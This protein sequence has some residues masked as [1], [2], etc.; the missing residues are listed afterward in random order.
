MVENAYET[1]NYAKVIGDPF[2]MRRTASLYNIPLD[3]RTIKTAY[4]KRIK[5]KSK[6]IAPVIKDGIE[7]QN[8]LEKGR[9]I[10]NTLN[11]IKN[12]CED[13]D[14]LFPQSLK[15][16]M[17][18]RINSGYKESKKEL[19]SLVDNGNVLDVIDK[20]PIVSDYSDILDRCLEYS[21]KDLLI[22]SL[23]NKF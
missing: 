5:E 21:R 7:N 14:L 15:P 13:S 20:Q 18:K 17:K 3:D 6:E 9:Y 4:K 23:K 1:I 12:D 16:I 2:L 19:F 22:E 10:V 8:I 11:E